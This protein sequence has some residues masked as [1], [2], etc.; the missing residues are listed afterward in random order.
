[1]SRHIAVDTCAN[2][3]TLGANSCSILNHP[4]TRMP[5]IIGARTIEHLDANL[6]GTDWILSANHMARL[7]EVSDPGLPYPYDF[8]ANAQ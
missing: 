2:I 8:I 3:D 6:G 1:M 7:S 5:V 4:S